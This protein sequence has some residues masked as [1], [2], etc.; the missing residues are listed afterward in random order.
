MISLNHLKAFDQ[1]VVCFS[2]VLAFRGPPNT[3][4]Y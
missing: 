3:G 4:I 1:A 2:F